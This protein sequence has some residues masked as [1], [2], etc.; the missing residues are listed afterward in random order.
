VTI[1]EEV[2]SLYDRIKDP[3]RPC[4]ECG[5]PLAD[6]KR[7]CLISIKLSFGYLVYSI[8]EQCGKVGTPSIRNEAKR[9]VE[10]LMSKSVAMIFLEP[11]ETVN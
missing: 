8:C 6:W 5:L 9:L 7:G 4:D 10:R 1:R 2:V 3:G 11:K